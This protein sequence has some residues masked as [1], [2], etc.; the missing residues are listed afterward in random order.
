MKQLDEYMLMV[1]AIMRLTI[2]FNLTRN[3]DKVNALLLYTKVEFPSD[4]AYIEEF[5]TLSL[6]FMGM[7][8]MPAV[9][10]SIFH[11]LMCRIPRIVVS[12]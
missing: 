6:K 10:A 2:D 8:R 11:E 1:D 9:Q 7:L 5:V 4:M 3:S 12:E